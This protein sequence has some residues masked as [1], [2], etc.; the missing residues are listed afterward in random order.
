MEVW[1]VGALRAYY[2][3]PMIVWLEAGSKAVG[4]PLPTHGYYVFGHSGGP[5][6]FRPAGPFKGLF[7][8]RE[9]SQRNLVF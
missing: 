4:G 7:E 9:W 1:T 3:D 8:A 6:Q 5:E 2:R